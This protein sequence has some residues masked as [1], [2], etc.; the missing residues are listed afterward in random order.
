MRH[1]ALPSYETGDRDLKKPSGG[2]SLDYGAQV[3]ELAGRGLAVRDGNRAMAFMA[4]VGRLKFLE[5]C[6]RFT[7]LT[8]SKAGKS[9]A[10]H[11][12]MRDGSAAEL[13]FGVNVVGLCPKAEGSMRF[14]EGTAFEDIECL[15]ALDSA[16]RA[17]IMAA[18]E[19]VEIDLR[20]TAARVFGGVYGPFGHVDGASFSPKFS[21]PG[22]SPR[23][24]ASPSSGGSQ[25]FSASR[26]SGFSLPLH[27]LSGRGEGRKSRFELWREK[28]RERA[29]LSEDEQI[30]Q[31]GEAHGKCP[32]LP[33]WAAMEVCPF[34]M[35]SEMYS[36]MARAERHAISDGYGL[37]PSTLASWLRSFVAVR[38]ICAHHSRLWDRRISPALR[39]PH[40][41]G[42]PEVNVAVTP[43]ESAAGTPKWSTAGILGESATGTPGIPRR[44]IF[45]VVLA[46][47]W[48]TQSGNIPTI[49]HTMWRNSLKEVIDGFFSLPHRLAMYTGFPNDW[50]DVM[51]RF[52]PPHPPQ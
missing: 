24:P 37:D 32:D 33:I 11:A 1:D 19:D 7:T 43:G 3:E 16:L 28:L 8:P 31:L 5:Y 30:R 46:L 13:R 2:K 45:A 12:P 47:N 34:G 22:R 26:S 10:P 14:K 38:N 49:R 42:T 25:R 21:S 18:M 40:L 50:E 44:S 52:S 39:I 35:L 20:S 51:N 36:G 17:C 48:M 4:H 9:A 23:C 15:Y 6:R 27:H 41:A 29:R